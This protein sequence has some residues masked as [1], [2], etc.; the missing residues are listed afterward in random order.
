M[1]ELK[2]GIDK[3]YQFYNTERFHQSLDYATPDEI[4]YG[5]FS[6]KLAA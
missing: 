4:Y 3:Y 5:A 2:E 6:V 1:K